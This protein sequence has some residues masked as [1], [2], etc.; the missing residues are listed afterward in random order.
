MTILDV[1]WFSGRALIGIVQVK[2]DWEGI[3]YYLTT[4]P[5]PSTPEADAQFIAD[6]GSTFP[7]AAGNVLFGVS[8]EI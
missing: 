2:D 5:N 4:V 1:Q 7:W 6:Y 8:N 3:K